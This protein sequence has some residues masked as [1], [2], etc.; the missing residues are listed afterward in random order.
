MKTDIH[1]SSHLAQFFFKWEM[2][3]TKVVEKIKTHILNSIIF[4]K[5]CRVW[6]NVEKYCRA[7]QATV[8]I[9]RKRNACWI[10]KTKHTHTHS[11]YVI[12]IAFP[13]QQWSRKIASKLRYRAL[14]VLCRVSHLT[15]SNGCT[16]RLNYTREH[17]VVLEVTKTIEVRRLYQRF[18]G[19]YRVHLQGDPKRSAIR[20]STS[21]VDT[22]RT[23]QLHIA[24]SRETLKCRT[25][26]GASP[27]TLTQ[28]KCYMNFTSTT[29]NMYRLS[30]MFKLSSFYINASHTVSKSYILI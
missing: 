13:L 7:G 2:F 5:S 20:S 23:T 6:D 26:G 15:Y 1:W 3:Q 22:Y 28:A 16:F 30:K 18:G 24:Q 21:P 25:H 27:L 8:T 17:T 10:A 29:L 9:R 19:T 4:F 11:E 12:F 14:P